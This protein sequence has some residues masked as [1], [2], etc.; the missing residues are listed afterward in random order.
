MDA[1]TRQIGTF[2][3]ERMQTCG[4]HDEPTDQQDAP[5]A[6]G[7]RRERLVTS[8]KKDVDVQAAKLTTLQRRVRERLSRPL[9]VKVGRTLL[10]AWMM[11]PDEEIPV[12]L[13]PDLAVM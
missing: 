12:H 10:S 4:L 13:R 1:D 5:S 8:E 2:I 7:R 6:L 11:H 9:L 3:W